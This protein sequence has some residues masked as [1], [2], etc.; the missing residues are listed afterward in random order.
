MTWKQWGNHS[1]IITLKLN[2]LVLAGF[3]IRVGQRS[4]LGWPRE[5]WLL[6]GTLLWDHLSRN[7][8][9]TCSLAWEARPWVEF[10]ATVMLDFFFSNASWLSNCLIFSFAFASFRVIVLSKAE[11]LDGLGGDSGSMRCLLARKVTS[12]TVGNDGSITSTLHTHKME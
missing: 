6:C 1:F 4:P 9:E 5:T 8:G 11:R 3:L 12:P 7:E 10:W 2:G